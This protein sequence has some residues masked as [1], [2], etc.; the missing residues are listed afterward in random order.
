MR[1]RIDDGQPK[2]QQRNDLEA[3]NGD[4]A[5]HHRLR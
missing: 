2:N 1:R 3:T 4:V 5:M